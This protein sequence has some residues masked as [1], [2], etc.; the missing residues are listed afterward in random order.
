[1]PRLCHRRRQGTRADVTAAALGSPAPSPG[2][3]GGSGAG[4]RLRS[5]KNYWKP[6]SISR[7][8][9]RKKKKN[10]TEKKNLKK[11]C[12]GARRK[13]SLPA[14]GGHQTMERRKTRGRKTSAGSSRRHGATRGPRPPTRPSS[15]TGPR[16]GQAVPSA[17]WCRARGWHRWLCRASVPT[18]PRAAR[19]ARCCAGSAEPGGGFQT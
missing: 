9:R 3:A 11:G 10:N 7:S 1:M 5:Q 6:L 14:L 19:R 2:R 16:P 18:Q 8:L 12:S 13:P 15:P 4:T 17:P